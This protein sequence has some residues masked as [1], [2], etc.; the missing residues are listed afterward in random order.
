MTIILTALFLHFI[1]DFVLQTREVATTKS[2]DWYALAHHCMIIWFS[3]IPLGVMVGGGFI[4]CMAFA[5]A[6][7]VIH[8]TIDRNIWKRYG[9]RIARKSDPTRNEEFQYWKDHVFYTVIGFDQFL[10]VSVLLLLLSWMVG[11]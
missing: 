7:A 9:Q 6:N 4:D 8:G 1:G 10:H 11:R 3:M 5:T 2:K